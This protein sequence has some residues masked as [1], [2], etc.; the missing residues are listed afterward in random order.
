MQE[1]INHKTDIDSNIDKIIDKIDNRQ[2]KHIIIYNIFI[3]IGAILFTSCIA[4]ISW[5]ISQS[6][7]GNQY[8]FGA[9]V[10]IILLGNIFVVYKF[11]K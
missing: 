6:V 1:I 2:A 10:P 4:S 8:F 7:F 9:I 5:I 11:I 3:A